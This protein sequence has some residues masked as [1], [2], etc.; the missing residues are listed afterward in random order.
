LVI[1]PA[2]DIAVFGKLVGIV[3]LIMAGH[4][5]FYHIVDEPP[6][7]VLM[8]QGQAAGPGK[9]L[10]ICFS[11][12]GQQ[13]VASAIEL[14]GVSVLGED[15]LEE[16]C[17]CRLRP[18]GSPEVILRAALQIML[19]LRTQMIS[20]R[21]VPARTRVSGV[22]RQQ[23]SLTV[24]AHE[25]TGVN[26]LHGF[27]DMSVRHAIIVFVSA[28]VN[29]IVLCHLV[30]AVIFEFKPGGRQPGEQWFFFGQKPFG[31]TIRFLLHPGLIVFGYFFGEGTVERVQVKKHLIT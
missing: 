26:H 13:P 23:G 4:L 9:G 8:F 5:V 17:K 11:R 7:V 14:F 1:V 10:G 15:F 29:M 16:H 21:R 20:A 19:V 28:Q 22:G 31:A 27:T 30:A 2:T 25:R 3:R 24:N 18:A 12:E 6:G